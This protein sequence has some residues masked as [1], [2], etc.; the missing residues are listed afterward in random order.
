MYIFKTPIIK[1]VLTSKTSDWM[2]FRIQTLLQIFVENVA[3]CY[4]LN[5]FP[6]NEKNSIVKT[7][8]KNIV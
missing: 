7:I 1:R 8:F 6:F 2:F 5:L 3:N 4:P